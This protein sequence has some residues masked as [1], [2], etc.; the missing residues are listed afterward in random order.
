[1]VYHILKLIIFIKSLLDLLLHNFTTTGKMQDSRNTGKV[2]GP[3]Y[4]AREQNKDDSV[5]KGSDGECSKSSSDSDEFI[6]Y[7][8]TTFLRHPYSPHD[9]LAFKY[10]NGDGDLEEAKTVVESGNEGR[11]AWKGAVKGENAN[12]F[13]LAEF[14]EWLSDGSDSIVRRYVKWAKNVEA[15]LVIIFGTL[16]FDRLLDEQNS[17]FYDSKLIMCNFKCS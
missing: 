8:P 16:S 13:P 15:V 2:S 10:F 9:I 17:K 5:Q 3:S 4:L 14:I 1:M 12:E 7:G 6:M 11:Y